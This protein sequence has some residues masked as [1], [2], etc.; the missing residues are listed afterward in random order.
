MSLEESFLPQESDV[1]G[2]DCVEE[3]LVAEFVN[4]AVLVM[5]VVEVW[6]ETVRRIAAA[7]S[8]ILGRAS[9]DSIR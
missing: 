5:T 7:A 1:V 3:E 8:R 6:R 2:C 4:G 9:L